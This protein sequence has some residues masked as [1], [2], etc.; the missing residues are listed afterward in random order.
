MGDIAIMYPREF[1]DTRQKIL[2]RAGPPLGS[3][4]GTIK[5]LLPLPCRSAEP[6]RSG[7]LSLHKYSGR[8]TFRCT[9]MRSSSAKILRVD[10]FGRCR[11]R[12]V[13][14]APSRGT[15]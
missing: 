4:A 14:V 10:F 7:R 6:H 3:L 15:R 11:N 13:L 9:C 8:V 5:E 2:L 1:H 12:A